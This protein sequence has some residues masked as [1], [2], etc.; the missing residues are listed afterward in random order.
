MRRKVLLISIVGL[1]LACPRVGM[2]NGS[3]GL[4]GG[5]GFWAGGRSGASPEAPQFDSLFDT[6]GGSGN[7]FTG[8][9]CLQVD[10]LC[11]DTTGG[12][13]DWPG[14]CPDLMSGLSDWR[15]GFQTGWSAMSHIPLCGLGVDWG[16][17]FDWTDWPCGHLCPP[18]RIPAPGAALLVGIGAGLVGWM[19]RRRVL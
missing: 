6:L 11:P 3:F 13:L 15:G 8:G 4:L 9:H 18:C 12:Y 19:R 17:S 2:A 1:G 10:G 7:L 5:S 14:L 16:C